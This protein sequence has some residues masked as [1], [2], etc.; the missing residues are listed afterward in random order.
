M[1][2]LWERC[3]LR[4]GLLLGGWRGWMGELNSV[5]L[6][7]RGIVGIDCLGDPCS[8]YLAAIMQ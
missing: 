2:S 4:Q 5:I 7:G 6:A 1:A 3:L 8:I